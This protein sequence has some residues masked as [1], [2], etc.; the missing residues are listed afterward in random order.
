MHYECL[1]PPR[2]NP[3]LNCSGNNHMKEENYSRA[4]ECYSQAIDL[5][6]RNAVYYCNR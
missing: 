5:D 1:N 3:V 4:M 6:L 2:I